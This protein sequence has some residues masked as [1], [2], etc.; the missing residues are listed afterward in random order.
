[1]TFSASVLITID[2]KSHGSQLKLDEASLRLICES[3]K[4]EEPSMQIY[5]YDQV[6]VQLNY[7]AS[8]EYM[9]DIKYGQGIALSEGSGFEAPLNNPFSYICKSMTFSAKILEGELRGQDVSVIQHFPSPV[10]DPTNGSYMF[11]G[12]RCYV[13]GVVKGVIDENANEDIYYMLSANRVWRTA[14][15]GLDIPVL[16]RGQVHR[17]VDSLTD[18][19]HHDKSNQTNTAFDC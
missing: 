10:V 13:S 8:F 19:L 7:V 6:L 16:L 11:P 18:Y 5:K 3:I 12:R 14:N 15:L 2:K 1:M 4:S 9:D 17:L